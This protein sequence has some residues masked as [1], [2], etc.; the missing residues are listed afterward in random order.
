MKGIHPILQQVFQDFGMT[1]EGGNMM[2][3]AEKCRAIANIYER[4]LA[5]LGRQYALMQLRI[6]PSSMP[7]P[8]KPS[9]NTIEGCEEET[10]T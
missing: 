3:Y 7:S 8:T 2:S 5:L 6:S 9:P 10:P 4:E 1:P